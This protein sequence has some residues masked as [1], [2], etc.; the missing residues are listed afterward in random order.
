MRILQ[1]YV[2][3]MVALES[4]VEEALDLMSRKVEGHAE[5]VAAVT[6]FHSMVKSQREALQT[7]FLSIGGT[8]KTVGAEE[9]ARPVS[10]A[11]QTIYALFNRA[12]FGYAALHVVAHRHYDSTS[13]GNT[14][15]LAEKHLRSYTNATQVINQ[16]ISDVVVW[17]IG[18]VGQE[19][20]CRCPSCSLGI[21]LCSPHG[22]YTTNDVSREAVPAHDQEGGHGMRVRPP[23]AN[24]A[25]A[26]A[27][28]SSGDTI[29]AVDGQEIQ[30][31][32]ESSIGVLQNS[33][34][35]H[36]PGGEIQLRV[37]RSSGNLQAVSVTRP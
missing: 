11:L 1:R 10:A 4:Q 2:S 13:E 21:C 28:L 26:R 14:A 5:A 19:C 36:E 9:K 23:R 24:S 8:N 16:L 6:R 22:T 3:E 33:I 32:G 34:R 27:G 30:N 12:A 37:Q 7:R 25:A 29:V 17:E 20:Q 35:K 18:K 15:D 31:E